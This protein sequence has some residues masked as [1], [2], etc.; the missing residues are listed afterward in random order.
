MELK[1]AL[2]ALQEATARA[3]AAEADLS[4]LIQQVGIDV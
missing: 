1:D 4:R 2:I 3:K